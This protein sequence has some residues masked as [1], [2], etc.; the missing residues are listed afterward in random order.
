[1]SDDHLWRQLLL[2]LILI[3]VNAF[4]AASEI[5]MV[6]LNINKLKKEA[7][8]GDKRAARMLKLAEQPTSFLSAI[9]IGITLAGF[10][11]SAFAADNFSERLVTWL[12]E[13][14]IPQSYAGTLDALS[15][16]VVTLIL[17][18]FTLVLGELVPK[19][20]G[21]H[22]PYKVAC[23]TTPVV[24]IVAILLKPVIWLLS[25][26]TKG[27]LLLCGIKD[28]GNEEKVT[29]DDIRLMADVGEETGTIDAMERE[30]IDNIFEF[31]NSTAKDVMTH[32]SEISSISIDA[33]EQDIVDAIAECGFSRIPVWEERESNIIGVLI[34]KEYFINL[35]AEKPLALREIIRA[36]YFIPETVSC[37]ALFTEMQ[38]SQKHIAI[39]IDEYGEPAGIVTMEDLIEEIVG[40]IYDESDDAVTEENLIMELGEGEWRISGHAELDAVFEK[41]ELDVPEDVEANTFGGLVI[42][43]LTEIPEEGAVFEVECHGLHIKVDS[44]AERRVE[45]A[46]VTIINPESEQ[47]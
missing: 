27:C 3:L 7:E 32:S 9:Q 22:S 28:K 19:R 4:F 14:G 36:P 42:G 40:N 16:V 44:F 31:G 45:S 39:V 26:T 21:M 1:M 23:F 29:E 12:L 8:E 47:E 5:S 15:V 13:L 20:I 37:D 41:L 2:Q 11:G 43:Q 33:S 10:L 6:S 35:R 17:S 46:V 30:M 18:F 34:V 24:R 25:V 38:N